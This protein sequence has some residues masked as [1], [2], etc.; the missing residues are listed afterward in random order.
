MPIQTYDYGIG[1]SLGDSLVTARPLRMSGNVWYVKSGTGADAA[2]PAGQQ[3]ERPLATLAQAHTNAAAGDVIVLLD[4]HTETLAA[5]Q[6]FNKAGITLVGEGS[7]SGVPTVTFVQNHATNS[8]FNVTAAGVK[9]RNIK[10][11]ESLISTLNPRVTWSG[12]NG[13]IRGC[14]FACGSQ[15]GATTVQLSTGA[16]SFLLHSS[17]FVSTT[18][19]GTSR[20]GAGFLVANALSDIDIFNC[21]FDSGAHGFAGIAL[22]APALDLSAAAITRLRIEALSILRGA[23]YSINASTTGYV[24]V[25]TA[26]GGSRGTW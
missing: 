10:L 13:E 20:P 26:T 12:A 4:G 14:Y 6:T 19:L 3:R 15:D 17:T 16:S 5:T 1:G 11:A 18:A 8:I 9:M 2:S 21:V 22:S 23:D 25:Q 7:S 24:N